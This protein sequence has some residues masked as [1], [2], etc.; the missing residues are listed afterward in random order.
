[1]RNVYR[2]TIKI[3]L[4]QTLQKAL[5]LIAHSIECSAWSFVEQSMSQALCYVL[6]RNAE[7]S[8]GLGL[9]KLLPEKEEGLGNLQDEGVGK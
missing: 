7:Q 3:C 1:M 5:I 9:A 2:Y 4:I 6:E 8:M